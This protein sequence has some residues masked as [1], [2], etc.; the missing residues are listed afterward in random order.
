MKLHFAILLLMLMLFDRSEAQQ[1]FQF[2]Q[3]D[4][5]DS[6]LIDVV[7]MNASLG[8]TPQMFLTTGYTY[9]WNFGNGQTS[10]QE[11]PQ[12][13]FYD[14]PGTYTIDYQAVIDTVGFYL[15]GI[16]V[17]AVGCTDPFWGNPDPYIII[18][19]ASNQI[20]YSTQANYY[21]NQAPPYYWNLNMLLNNPPYFLWVWDYDSMDADDN[22]V[23][24][25]ESIPGA[26][27]LIPLPPNNQSGFGVTFYSGVNVDLH[28]A[29]HYNKP[30]TIVNE[31][32]Q[33]TIH[34]SPDEPSLSHQGGTFS[35]FDQIPVV[36]AIADT[37][38]H[39]EWFDDAACSSHI[40]TGNNFQFIP[41]DTGVFHLWARQLNPVTFCHSDPV[42]LTF[43]IFNPTGIGAISEL[44][45]VKVYPN[46]AADV[47]YVSSEEITGVVNLR[48]FDMKGILI[49]DLL[50]D[51]PCKHRI[52][53]SNLSNGLYH[54]SF[55]KEDEL[56]LMKKIVVIK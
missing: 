36:I 25:S 1:H 37:G 38:N 28:Y 53:V 27:T 2:I 5:C 10:S 33:I 55:Q 26:S 14:Q 40:H 21:N 15:I 41:A 50:L 39:V 30:V 56:P 49:E 23:N 29:F 45:F 22:C 34:A 16:D 7:N 31:Q 8:Y 19:D 24:N 3:H 44:H 17:T 18:R 42:H 46:P 35:I 54:L 51:F 11:S 43:I 47:L 12:S 32:Q 4:M 20:I 9:S 13:I 6:T 48:V 52:D